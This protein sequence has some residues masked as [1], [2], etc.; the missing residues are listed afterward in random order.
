MDV[1]HIDL[2]LGESVTDRA[3]SSALL[4]LNETRAL[5]LPFCKNSAIK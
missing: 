2:S 4:V 3:A 1:E 5:T